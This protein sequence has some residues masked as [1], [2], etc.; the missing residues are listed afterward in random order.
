[1]SDLLGNTLKAPIS[2]LERFDHQ[3]AA[4]DLLPEELLPTVVTLAGGDLTSRC[5][6]IS[7]LRNQLLSGDEVTPPCCW[8]PEPV[9]QRIL[10]NIINSGVLPFC[11]DNP[12]VT[13]ALLADLLSV[14]DGAQNH[15]SKL[16]QQLALIYQQQALE[17]I[18]QELEQ[19]QKRR[20]VS[21]AKGKSS[22]KTKSPKKLV[23]TDAQRLDCELNAELEAW[24]QTIGSSE[25]YGLDLPDIWQERVAVW[26]SLQEVFTDL[27]LITG[28]G[29]DLSKG[30]LQSHGWMNMV[31][32][33]K[34][35]EQIPKLREVIET[36]GRMKDCDGEPIIEEIISK[37]SVSQRRNKEMATPLVP[38]ET[39]GITRSDS[40]SRMLPQEAAFLGHPV[41]KK[42]WH[43][44]RAEHA[45]LCYAVE[46]KEVIAEQVEI[47]QE[48]KRQKAG[49]SKNRNRG[50]MI[51]CLDTSG[52]MSG[53]PENVAKALV[54]QCIST[55]KAEQRACY[56]YLFGSLGEVEEL[57][58][59]PD[60]EGVER[61]ILFLSMS[62][63]GGTDAEGPLNLALERS[64]EHQWQQADILLVS[65]GEFSLSSGLSRKIN[66]RKA[67][68]ALSVH[69]VIIGGHVSPMNKICDPLHQFASWIDFQQN[70]QQR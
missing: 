50:P 13:D 69:G 62:F 2:V 31:R 48:V 47:E 39:K 6:S 22:G 16:S 1:M 33:Q 59:T 46:G 65:D 60:A 53:T 49:A 42:L 68:R 52:S 18:R 23:L 44:R 15:A 40:I 7:T 64:D 20:R 63:G 17:Q 10:D 38:M 8:L 34:L 14:L 30:M 11:R 9:Q 28:L 56:V 66:K 32:L 36:L 19:N 3:F 27:G 35:L 58:L 12:Q 37:M 57:E 29:W 5:Q 26:Q 25:G 55:A 4:I 51:V 21:S 24:L 45:L 54:L 61:M 43:A 67:E 41:L 70:K